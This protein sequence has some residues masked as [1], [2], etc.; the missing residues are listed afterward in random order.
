MRILSFHHIPNNGAFLFAYSLLELFQQEFNEFDVKILDYK[1]NRLA[2]YEY[3][4]RFKFF[5]NPPLFYMMRARMWRKQIET[6]FELDSDIPHFVGEKKLQESFF[7]KYDALVVGMDTWCIT[8]GTERPKFPNIYWLPEN[9]PVPKLAYGV[10]AYNS[11]L[12]L[13][14]HSA[15]QVS[16]YLDGFDIIGV[17]D[18]FTYQLVQKYRS[19]RDG[20]VEIIPDPTFMYDFRN[21]NVVAKL[22]S[23]GVDLNRPI[24]GV[25][26]FGNNALTNRVLTHY[27]SK[28]YQILAMSMYN[29]KADFNLGHILTP[30]EWAEAFR[31]FSFCIGDRFHGTIF[32]LLNQTPFVS[33][34][35]DIHLPKSQSKTLDLLVGFGLET[36]YQNPA[37]KDFNVD[38]LLSH[39]NQIEK[40]WE[41]SFKPGI[42][43]KIIA[44]RQAH[45]EFIYKMKKELHK[46]GFENISSDS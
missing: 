11:D 1:S 27:K 7:N 33:I 42:Q 2:T 35:K 39:A 26:L 21:T 10:S 9:I 15:K 14:E 28:G 4:K 18:H 8:N 44:Q 22:K 41:S 38:F 46:L 12:N 37:D 16:A 5:Q 30:F 25:L 19:R 13:I 23:L 17:R 36:C 6:Y 43:A 24:L 29:A 32:C 34:E 20:L 3:L 45:F 40:S 31:Y